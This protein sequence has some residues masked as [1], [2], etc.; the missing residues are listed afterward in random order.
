MPAITATIITF[1]EEDRIAEAIASLP[2]CDEVIVVDAGSTDRTREIAYKR[3]ARVIEHPWEGYSK[4]KNYAAEL[5]RNDW[6]LSIDADERL[7]IELADEIVSWKFSQ[8]ERAFS[9]PR[10]VFYL[11]RWI[12]HSGWYP[13]R[14][15][16]LYDRRFCRWE[17]DFVHEWLKVDGGVGLFKGDLLHFPYRDWNDHVTR[18]GRY[19]DLAARAARSSGLRGS[20]VKLLLAPPLTFVKSFFLHGGFLDGWRGL[21][22]AYMGA[23]YV[24]QKEFRILR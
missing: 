19:T 8:R 20:I 1:N 23:R 24:F 14:K 9:M 18:I 15:I 2:C 10:R 17:G 7:S 16:R 12:N 21:A 22:I 6:I 5:A 3:G 13:D 4:Q 11:G